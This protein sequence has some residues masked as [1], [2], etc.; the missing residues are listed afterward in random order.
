MERV[1]MVLQGEMKRAEIQEA[2][3]L[4]HRDSFTENYLQPAL[5]EGLVEMTIPNKPNSSRQKYRL[6]EK[7]LALKEQIENK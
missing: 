5:S 7:G 6:T 3:Q 4:K 2:L 1:V